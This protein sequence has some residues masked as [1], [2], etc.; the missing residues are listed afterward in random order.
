MRAEVDSDEELRTFFFPI[1]K[2]SGTLYV[3]N[4]N[5]DVSAFE[6]EQA[7]ELAPLRRIESNIHQFVQKLGPLDGRG[8]RFTIL[9]NRTF[10]FVKSAAFAADGTPLCVL[11]MDEQNNTYATITPSDDV[12][13]GMALE[14]VA[15]LSVALEV[16][17]IVQRSGNA[18]FPTTEINDLEAPTMKP[19]PAPLAYS[20]GNEL[21]REEDDAARTAERRLAL[22]AAIQTTPTL[23]GALRRV[24]AA[25]DVRFR[26]ELLH[27]YRFYASTT[28]S[29]THH[30]E[31]IEV[32]TRDG[33]PIPSLRWP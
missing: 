18:P 8:M 16:D 2:Q 30:V 21:I 5:K 13:I 12:A 14:A 6:V 15:A 32:L 28:N 1:L 17:I 20:Y 31:K 24:A 3:Y 19:V 25:N 27:T 10:Y 9:S 29:K 23:G 33:T 11:T 4:T 22:I 26:E 7:K